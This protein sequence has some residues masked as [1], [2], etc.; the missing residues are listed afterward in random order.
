VEDYPSQRRRLGA[1]LRVLRE[2]AGLSTRQ[3]AAGIGKDQSK[4]SRVERGLSPAPPPLVE[5]WARVC[6][7]SAEQVADLREQALLALAEGHPAQF[8]E[9][10]IAASQERMRELEASA[11][12]VLNFSNWQA[13]GLL[14]TADYMRRMFTI[15]GVVDIGRSIAARLNRQ[16]ILYNGDKRFEFLLPEAALTYRIGP[17]QL[18]IAQLAH[19]GQVMTLENITV[20]ILPANAPAPAPYDCSIALYLDRDD[21]RPP[22]AVEETVS[23]GVIVEAPARVQLHTQRYEALRSAGV[24]G[25]EAR[26]LLDRISHDLRRGD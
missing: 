10:D 8:G 24:F 3:V 25:D 17:P 18:L 11:Q 13:P 4:V 15:L 20:G 16:L 7:A 26:V 23:W 12:V 19:Y 2:H 14:Q 6:D 5:A 1:A 22:A 21:G 9:G